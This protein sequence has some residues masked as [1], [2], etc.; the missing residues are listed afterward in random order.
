MIN[1]ERDNSDNEKR[2]RFDFINRRT[3]LK[4]S[5]AFVAVLAASRLFKRPATGVQPKDVNRLLGSKAR[6]DIPGDE[7]ITWEMIG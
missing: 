4:L 2:S 6:V 3:F 5:A 1:Q 7:V